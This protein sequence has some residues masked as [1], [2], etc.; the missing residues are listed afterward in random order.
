MNGIL[1]LTWRHMAFNKAKTAIMVI[2]LTVTFFLPIAVNTLIHHYEADMMARARSTPLIVGAKGNRYDLALKS[3]YFTTESPDAITMQEA[4]AVRDSGRATP[5]PLHI[6]HT[7]KGRPVVGTDLDYFAFRGLRV[8]AGSLPVWLGDAVLGSQ[9]AAELALKPGD[10]L[11]TDQD[12]LYD[13]GAVY[14]LKM[15]IVG[16]LAP[17]GS[18][19]DYAVF[20]DVK[21]AWIIDGIGHGHTDLTKTTDSSIILE[22]KEGEVVGS[23]ATV[24][25]T[26]ITPENIESFHIHGTDRILP[27]TSVIVLPYSDRDATVLKARYGV[28]ATEQMIEPLEVIEELMGIVFKIKT[29]FDAIFLLICLAMALFVALVAMLSLKLRSREM[30]TMF[31]L[32]CSRSMTARLQLAELAM[33]VLISLAAAGV[34]SAL[35]LGFAPKLVNV[36]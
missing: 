1:I 26:E 19:D 13:I 28:S 11:M 29:F 12:R 34:L 31:R 36:M 9:V 8:A 35:L 33:V 14:P 21:T 2:C 32:G 25:F 20:V 23:A 18:P 24:I 16:I 7:A 4:G 22:R 5:I 27:L 6:Q 17:A 15:K 10:T 30:Q 3:L